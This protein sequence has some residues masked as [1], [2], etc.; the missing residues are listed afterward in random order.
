MSMLVPILVLG[1]I[2][3]VMG[4]A[5]AYV[6]VDLQAEQGISGIG[7]G[8]KNFLSYG[9]FPLDDNWNT[10]LLPRG[11][12]TNGDI[13]N[14][15]ALEFL[16]LSREEARRRTADLLGLL[17]LLHLPGL[18]VGEGLLLAAGLIWLRRASRRSRRERP[19]SLAHSDLRSRSPAGVTASG[20]PGRRPT[21]WGRHRLRTRSPGCA[22]RCRPPAAAQYAR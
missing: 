17:G 20:R 1:G 8:G 10:T 13:A 3:A 19:A 16:G 2:G 15:V 4:L 9:G 7:G 21:P 6:S 22:P 11:V 14:P 18:L 12:V 5:M